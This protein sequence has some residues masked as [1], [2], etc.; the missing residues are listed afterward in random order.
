M[1]TI[2]TGLIILTGSHL[3]GDCSIRLLPQAISSPELRV[4]T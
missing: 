4:T 3:H 2:H 1:A